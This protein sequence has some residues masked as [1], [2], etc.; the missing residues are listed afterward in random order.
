LVTKKI[1]DIHFCLD[2]VC[3]AFNFI[4]V[5]T[6]NSDL[7]LKTWIIDCLYG[8]EVV[9]LNFSVPDTMDEDWNNKKSLLKS[10]LKNSP[11]D[12]EV[13]ALKQVE[14]NPKRDEKNWL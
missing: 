11:F 10:L 8:E 7:S 1:I 2:S 9:P 3:L 6:F 13:L 4:V 14:K 5:E 12:M